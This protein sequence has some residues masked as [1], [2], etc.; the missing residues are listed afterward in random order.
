METITGILAQIRMRLG[1]LPKRTWIMIGGGVLIA[2]VVVVLIV[3]LV[4]G[5][6]GAYV[7]L[8]A[9]NPTTSH[10]DGLVVRLAEGTEAAQVEIESIP[11]ETFLTGQADKSW[12]AA[13]EALPAYLTPLSPI[14]T[15][16]GR[17]EGQIVAEMA[18]PNEADPLAL[19]D[20]YRWDEETGAWVF[21]PGDQDQARQV[22]VFQPESLPISV[23]AGRVEPQSPAVGV[24][25]SVGSPD[26]DP[27]YGLAILEGVYISAEGEFV[28]EPVSGD[29]STVMPLIENRLGGLTTYTDPARQDTIVNY[30]M[31]LLT[32]Y[33]GLV[34]DFDPGEGY[35]ELVARLAEE[36]HAHGKRLDIVLRGL[37]P[38]AY[39]PATLARHA[40]HILV[41]PGDNPTVYL[42]NGPAQEMLAGLVDMV[43][44]NKLGLLVSGLNVDVSGES[45]TPIQTEDAMALFGSIQ[46]IEG[47]IDPTVPIVPGN[48]VP[49]RLTGQIDSMGFDVPLGM[50]Y[51]TYHD[52]A[53]QLHHVYFGSA[54]N[55]KRKLA[56][57]RYYGLRTVVVHG[58][59]HPDAPHRLGDGISA[60][61]NQQPISDPEPLAIVWRTQ[62]SSGASLS[63][64]QGDLTLLQY[65]WQAVAEPGLYVVS[66]GISGQSGESGRGQ[67]VV[68]VGAAPPNADQPTPTAT[69]DPGATPNPDETSAPAAE[70]TQAPVGDAIAPGAFELGGQ[71]HTL[72]HPDA[73]RQ[74]GMTW[75][76]FQHKW[77]RGDDPSG[78]VGGRISQAHSLGF[79]VLLSI[80]GGDHPDAID[81]NAYVKY[82][83]GVA[84]LG[85]DAIEVWNEMNLDREWPYGQIDGANYVNNMLAPA[86]QAIKAANPNVM[87]ISGA[88]SPTGYWG[89]CAPEG[90]DDWFYLAQMRDAGAANHLDCVGIHYNEGIIPPSQTSGDP[91]SEHYTRYFFGMLDLYYGTFGKPLCFTEL[92]YLSPEG[93]GALPQAFSWAQNTSVAEQAAWLA[94]AAVLSSQ[95]GKVRLMIIFN[96]DF[97][98]YGSDPQ[99]GYAIIRPGGG[100]PA[101]DTLHAVQP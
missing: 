58:L 62:T 98:V 28:G 73:M 84:A 5:R 89:G 80:P 38:S 68:E 64:A 22:I 10:P 24:I 60:F 12:R 99:G 91:R 92:G 67:V 43:D 18:I 36:V 83:A 4:P 17:D 51:L 77:G 32:P 59:V 93:Y 90:C 66:A 9:A 33:D 7:R 97:T 81:Y 71:T 40:D 101:C 11:R 70:P 79:K 1:S 8:D 61:L 6:D 13:R 19:L 86:Y 20:L 95:S 45:V 15:V 44:R 25:F 78:S 41:A 42:P 47:Y 63:Q 48:P 69:P 30:L 2:A 34:L 26:L 23:L 39:D 57:A 31:P 88:P 87:V 37:S 56:W 65:L 96:V 29:G 94:E 35:A 46:P 82:L 14:Y 16:R 54:Q 49:F 50:N 75:V 55:L 85:P 76:K 21:V 74:A 52:E 3:V 72:E 100:C 53:T 27:N